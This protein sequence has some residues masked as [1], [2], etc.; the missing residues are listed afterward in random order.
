MSQVFVIGIGG[1][2]MR[3]IEAFTH[4][5][6]I[7]MF[8]K[9][10]VHLLALDTDKDNGNFTRLKNLKEAYIKTK[11]VNKK[12]FAWENTFFSANLNYYQFSP[13]YSRLSSFN[14]LYNYGDTKF[15]NPEKAAIADLLFTDNAK[16]FDLKHGYRAQ[17]HLGSLLMYHSILDDVKMNDHSDLRKFIQELINACASGHPKVFILGSVFGGTGASSIP[18]IPKAIKKAASLISDATD[19]ER[20]AY[21]GATLLTSYFSFPLPNDAEKA[22]QKVIAASDKFALNSQAAMMFYEADE[23][24]KKT[25]QKFYMM[26]TE[27][28]SWQPGKIK[29]KTITGGEG[30]EN[31]SHYI[32][33]LAAFAAWHFFNS[34]EE[35]SDPAN[36]SLSG[37][38]DL[39]NEKRVEYLYRTFNENGK[40]DFTDFVGSE[41]KEELAK[42]IGLFTA[43]SYLVLLDNYN[44]FEQAQAGGL[45]KVKIDGYEDIDQEE[46][47]NLKKY[48][49]LYHFG[50]ENGTIKDGWLRQVHR[51]AGGGDK[52][53]L[54]P[55]IFGCDSIREFEK[56]NFNDTLFQKGSDFEKHKF[57]TGLMSNIIDK[58]Y[59]GFIK[60][61]EPESIT[62][63]NEKLIKRTYDTLCQLYE[64]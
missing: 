4:L 12:Q 43:M 19:I 54:H 3:C 62:N 7:G 30:Q 29:D 36:P 33:L 10:D 16:D 15:S 26:G 5:C 25:Y 23:T 22:K 6:A 58:F 2:G 53:L 32:E 44:F 38:E 48:M 45:K 57:K 37:L 24:V 46:V 55:D 63:K 49:S 9:T 13:D 60:A 59:G 8:D 14:A 51:S 28:L 20:N 41:K 35:G 31:D 11:G 56:F 21:F 64:F 17:T 27:T 42:K 34:V 47:R 61:S 18:I 50:V 52:F 40:I 39:K 1:T